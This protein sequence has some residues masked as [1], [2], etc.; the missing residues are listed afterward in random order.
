MTREVIE[1]EPA[2]AQ[3]ESVRDRA[4]LL[5]AIAAGGS[6]GAVARHGL[7]QLWPTAP[8]G[9]PWATFATNVSG[10][11]LI[12]ILM[13]LITEVWVGH[14]LLRPFLGVG[15]LGGFTTFSTYAGETRN[16]LRPDTIGLAFGYLA[17]TLVCALLATLLGARLTRA[18]AAARRRGHRRAA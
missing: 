5:G 12:G 14:R 1:P 4:T 17:G 18:A 3:R 9:F 10:C 8:G 2:R 6:V 16:L 13:V 7:A 11:L 15:V